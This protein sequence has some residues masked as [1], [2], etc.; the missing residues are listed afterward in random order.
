MPFLYRQRFKFGPWYTANASKSGI[1]H[2][3]RFWPLPLSWNSRQRRLRLD[4]PGPFSWMSNKIGLGAALGRL[5][6]TVTLLVGIPSAAAW[7]W[8]AD[9]A[10]W[11]HQHTTSSVA[12]DVGGQ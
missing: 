4:L 3:V 11:W 9:L 7:Y 2:T 12:P 1:S 5:V 10:Q 6:L 8:R